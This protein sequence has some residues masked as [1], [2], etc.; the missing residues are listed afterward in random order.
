VHTRSGCS[1]ICALTGNAKL[2]LIN[3]IL[4]PLGQVTAYTQG[5]V[6]VRD[7]ARLCIEASSS[8]LSN[9]A[10]YIE[11]I[12]VGEFG[13]VLVVHML[14]SI[15]CAHTERMSCLAAVQLVRGGWYVPLAVLKVWCGLCG[16]DN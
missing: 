3:S 10:W 7:N 14:R 6:T 11:Y 16:Y 1:Y 9:P 13:D 4:A 12:K 8:W 15:S 2:L 5:N